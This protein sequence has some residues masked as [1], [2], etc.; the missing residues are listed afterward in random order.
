MHR[1]RKAFMKMTRTLLPLFGFLVCLGVVIAGNACSGLS[2]SGE[3]CSVY[4]TTS[5]CQKGLNCECQTPGCFCTTACD[6]EDAGAAACH[7]GLV[8][9]A[10]FRPG[11]G[12][13]GY[14]CFP[15]DGG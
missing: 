7:S 4:S 2:G 10:G 14:F 12:Q 8:C 1:P 3:A 9:G 5:D 6:P 15:P 11:A 13:T